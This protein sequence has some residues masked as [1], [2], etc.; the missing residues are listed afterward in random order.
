MVNQLV[1]AVTHQPDAAQP[2][3]PDCAYDKGSVSRGRR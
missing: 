2:G 3:V 1:C